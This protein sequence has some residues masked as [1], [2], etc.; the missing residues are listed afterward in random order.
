M[1]SSL[2]TIHSCVNVPNP[3]IEW[4]PSSRI[5]LLPVLEVC[6]CRFELPRSSKKSQRGCAGHL[7]CTQIRELIK[8]VQ[9]C[10]ISRTRSF[11]PSLNAINAIASFVEV[12][13]ASISCV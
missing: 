13:V 3:V 4:I 6:E 7:R 1:R 2:G 8:D 10:W 5:R 12:I 9:S 11:M